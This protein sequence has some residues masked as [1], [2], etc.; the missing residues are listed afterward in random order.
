MGCWKRAMHC[1]RLHTH[2]QLIQIAMADVYIAQAANQSLENR[3][4]I[5]RASQLKRY[6]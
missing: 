4:A 5:T 3:R 2:K 6:E 1:S